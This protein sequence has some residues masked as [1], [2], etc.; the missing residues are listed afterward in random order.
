MKKMLV[1]A[2]LLLVAGSGAAMADPA[3]PSAAV[4][5]GD[6]NLHSPEGIATLYRRI[7]RASVAVC[8]LPQG[9]RQLKL[10]SELKAC[11]ADATDRAIVAANLPRLNSLHLART[12]RDVSHPRYADRR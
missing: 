7:E 10:E 8:D 12:G 5:Y 11:R 6:L 3:A 9:T 1:R 4:K 2:I